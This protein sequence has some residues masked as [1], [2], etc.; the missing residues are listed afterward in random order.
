MGASSG[1]GRKG[2][3]E[4]CRG[5]AAVAPLKMSEVVAGKLGGSGR[6]GEH[7]EWR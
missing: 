2:R 5:V 3:N 7:L 4:C 1:L 6:A